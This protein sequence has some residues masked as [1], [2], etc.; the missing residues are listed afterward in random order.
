MAKTVMYP[1]VS[2]DIDGT[3]RRNIILQHS[4]IYN[5]KKDIY[6]GWMEKAS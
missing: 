1:P 3:L 6:H 5:N 2:N 4:A